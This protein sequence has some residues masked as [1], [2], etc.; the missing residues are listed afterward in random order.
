VRRHRFHGRS[1]R[2]GFSLLE[3]CVVLAILGILAAMGLTAL[4]RWR[5]R[6]ALSL[7]PRQFMAALENAR[8]LSLATS[9]D[10]VLV[11]VGNA[12]PAQAAGCREPAL[13]GPS[14]QACVRY[15][16]LEDLVDA[17]S[18]R[19]D[20][21]AL[22]A[23]NP[24]APGAL[25][26]VVLEA[27]VLPQGVYLGRHPGYTPPTVDSASSIYA[28]LPL[29]AACSFCTAGPPPR[30]FVRFRADGSVQLS[31]GEAS[32]TPRVGG[33]LFFGVAGGGGVL[34]DTRLVSILQPAGLVTD[35][36]GA[37]LH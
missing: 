30:G 19:F 13:T 3:L 34:P 8:N 5:Q 33:T 17:G 31:R 24:E 37:T 36:L 21:E 28:G 9:R 2:A 25:G 14:A 35:R 6:E 16:L 26:D 18:E 20:E 32:E 27:D 4:A 1:P 29:G 7:A 15:W 11:V 10:V 12:G 23:F 22:A